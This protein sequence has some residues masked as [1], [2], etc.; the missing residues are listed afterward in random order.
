[1]RG[2]PPGRVW[3]QPQPGLGFV[4]P[5]AAISQPRN[6]EISV[7]RVELGVLGV[8][9]GINWVYFSQSTHLIPS[10]WGY[11]AQRK[12]KNFNSSPF[13]DLLLN[14]YQVTLDNTITHGQWPMLNGQCY[15]TEGFVMSPLQ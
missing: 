12:K 6:L 14:K 11:R 10:L 1:M 4:S 13:E 9:T 8:V 5:A 3:P 7:A 2:C 15:Q